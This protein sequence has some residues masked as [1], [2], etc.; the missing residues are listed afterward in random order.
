MRLL[1]VTIEPEM[2]RV[3]AA[4]RRSSNPCPSCQMPSAHVHSYYTRTVADLPCV[5]RRV[6]LHLRVRKFRCPNERCPQRVFTE[7]FPGFV[8]P[9]ARTT[10][11]VGEQIRALGR[12]LGG[13]GAER[14]APSLGLTVSGQTVVRAIMA[15]ETAAVDTSPSVRVLGVDDFAFRRASRYGTLLMDLEQRRVID[16]LPDR[17]QD[18]LAQWLHDHPDVRLITRDRGGEYAAGATIGAPQAQQI[19]DRFHLVLNAGEVLERYLTRQHVSLREAARALGPVDAPRRSTKRALVD[20]ERRQERRAARLA[21]YEQVVAL[22]QEGLSAHQI[23]QDVGVARATVYR[24]LAAACF[25]ERIPAQHPRQI[26]PYV[27]YLQERWN[28]GEHNAQTLWRDIHAQGYPGNVAPVR[29]LVMAWRTPP[30]QPG[31]AGQPLPA[32]KEAA[33]YSPRQ[34]GWLLTKAETELSSREVCYLTTLKR[35]CPQIAEAQHL[36]MTFHA[37]L[38]E[39]VAARLDGWLEQSEQSGIVEF[40]RFAHR[41]RYDY[42]A[43]S[44]AFCYPWSQGPVEGHINRLKLLKRQM[45]GRAGFALLRQRMLSQAT[46]AP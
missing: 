5:G 28:A 29:R 26:D 35:L 24:Y 33:S 10:L 13:R 18:T 41:L 3:H 22:A 43:V 9:K 32:K 6:V 39:R 4:A 34:T 7:R 21:R 8:R 37:L 16:L 1:A 20:I 14:L 23:A 25:P 15:D 11:R 38:D 42:A 12:A 36:V 40:V 44:A 27:A 46:R 30:P 17:S 19:A 45:Y 31:V 2:L